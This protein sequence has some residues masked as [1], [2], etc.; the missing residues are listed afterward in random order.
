MIEAMEGNFKKKWSELQMPNHKENSNPLLHF[1]RVYGL[2]ALIGFGLGVIIVFLATTVLGKPGSMGTEAKGINRSNPS[3]SLNNV[4]PTNQ[5]EKGNQGA[6]LQ[7]DIETGD[8]AVQNNPSGLSL[9]DR[10]TVLLVGMDN[11]PN[12]KFTGNTDSLI[13]ASIDQKNKKMILLSVPRDTQV[14]LP[15]KGKEKV[16]ALARLGKGI[17]STQE[18][19]Q[20][21]IGNPIDGYVMTNF[22]GFKNIVDSLGGITINV[23]KNMYFDTGDSKDR[24]IN[25]KKGNQ[26]LNGT[27][28]LQYARFRNDE[29]ADISRTSRQQE[30]LKAIVS[31]ATEARNLPKIP[32]L[33]PKIYQSIET[34]LNMSQL[35]SLAMVLKN[36]AEYEVINQTLPGKFSIEEGISYWKVEPKTSKEMLSKLIQGQKTSVFGNQAASA[37]QKKPASTEITTDSSKSEN[38]VL[39][40]SVKSDEA[41]ARGSEATMSHENQGITFEVVGP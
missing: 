35:W 19:I 13:V 27:Q 25:L 30:V 18:Y 14:L 41:K 2:N 29:L 22:Q 6:N 37:P 28:A 8:V 10:F 17:S 40:N 7:S 26:R 21:L 33:I 12:E 4:Q 20:E 16:N 5:S 24:Y 32:F 36:R 23:E 1:F 31:E 38:A 3:T 39:P 9:K 11:R 34:D 15:G